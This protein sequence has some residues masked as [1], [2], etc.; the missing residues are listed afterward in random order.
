MT[1]NHTEQQIKILSAQSE[2]LELIINQLVADD[3]A[4]ALSTLES[5]KDIINNNLASHQQTRKIEIE[6]DEREI[7]TKIWDEPTDD[8][9]LSG[10][11]ADF[12][13]D[14]FD[15]GLSESDFEVNP[16]VND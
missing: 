3:V 10:S 8:S 15:D 6:Y 4:T 12:V 13:V 11:D 9:E 1:E 2:L 14:D 16:A 5:L 7:D